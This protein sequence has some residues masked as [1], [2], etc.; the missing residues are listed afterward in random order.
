MIKVNTF[1]S[2]NKEYNLNI[3]K[4]MLS[5]M[6]TSRVKCIIIIF[7]VHKKKHDHYDQTEINNQINSIINNFN[8]FS[9]D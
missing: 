9:C 3:L 2:K 7:Y 4:L 6:G 5:G 1:E 8:T